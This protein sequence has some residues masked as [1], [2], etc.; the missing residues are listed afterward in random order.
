MRVRQRVPLEQSK[1]RLPHTTASRAKMASTKMNIARPNANLARLENSREQVLARQCARI[2]PRV[3]TKVRRVRR[4][5]LNAPRAS[6]KSRRV[7][8]HA[9]AASWK[10][11]I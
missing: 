4:R 2:A 1:R 11:Y 8:L 3:S 10:L 6:P 5:A 7:R 9:L